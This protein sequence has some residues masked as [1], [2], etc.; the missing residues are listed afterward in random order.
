MSRDIVGLAGH[1]FSGCLV[2]LLANLAFGAFSL[3]YW[4]SLVAVVV[5]NLMIGFGERSPQ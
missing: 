4:L 1:I 3:G 5:I 2:G